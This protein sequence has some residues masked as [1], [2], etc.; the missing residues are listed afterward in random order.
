M[1]SRQPHWVAEGSGAVFFFFGGVGV[2]QR[3]S[4]MHPSP[5]RLVSCDAL[6]LPLGPRDVRAT[7]ASSPLQGREAEKGTAPSDAG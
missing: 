7:T 2:F 5:P 3:S 1:Q 6:P 4:L